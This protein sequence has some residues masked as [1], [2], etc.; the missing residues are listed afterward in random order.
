MVFR[1]KM[2]NVFLLER[3][4]YLLFK[5]KLIKG[6]KKIYIVLNNWIEWTKFNTYKVKD[7]YLFMMIIVILFSIDCIV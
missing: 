2:W 6:D 5:I 4:Y 7:K 3:F 1:K